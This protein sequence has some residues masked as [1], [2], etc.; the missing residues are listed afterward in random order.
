M[1]LT[2]EFEVRDNAGIFGLVGIRPHSVRSD[3][4]G[5]IG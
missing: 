2:T 4:F 1:E 3:N 5:T